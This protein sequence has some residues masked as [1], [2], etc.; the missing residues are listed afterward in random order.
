MFDVCESNFMKEKIIKKTCMQ[1][2]FHKHSFQRE[3]LD[4]NYLRNREF[5]FQTTN[6]CI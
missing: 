3:D 2:C 5:E 1:N 6:C 4:V